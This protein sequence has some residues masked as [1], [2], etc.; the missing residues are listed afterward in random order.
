[1]S[2]IHDHDILFT[3]SGDKLYIDLEC[4]YGQPCV[5]TVHLK[6]THGG[7]EE[8]L[9]FDNNATQ[10]V[11]GSISKVKYNSLD[12]H[13]TIQDIRDSDTEKEDIS[14][15]IKVYDT[16][17]NFVDTSFTLKTKGKGTL[18]HSFYLVTIL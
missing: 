3:K 10:K 1:M 13:T 6:K 15:K 12:I 4:G 8:L 18:F 5:T 16:D 14:L 2:N 9:S 11:I 17:T 7:S